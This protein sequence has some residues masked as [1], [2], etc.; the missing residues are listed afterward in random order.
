MGVRV[1][2]AKRALKRKGSKSGIK[3]KKMETRAKSVAANRKAHWTAYKHFQK[4]V[5]QAWAKLRTDVKRK[6]KPQLLIRDK[7]QL[8]LLLGECNYMARECM[9]TSTKMK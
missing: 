1:K 9:R 7:N 4:R 8:L 5:D 2:R 3:K 6:V